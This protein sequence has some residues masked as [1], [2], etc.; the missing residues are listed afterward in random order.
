MDLD[1]ISPCAQ[2]FRLGLLVHLKFFAFRAFPD[3]AMWQILAR[4]QWPFK[5]SRFALS[6]VAIFF[7]LASISNQHFFN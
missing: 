2:D 4:W 5:P 6:L 7:L 3:L 1:I